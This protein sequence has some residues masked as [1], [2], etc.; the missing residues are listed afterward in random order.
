MS[1][2]PPLPTNTTCDIYRAGN[3]PPAPPD[4]AGVPCVLIPHSRNIKPPTTPPAPYTHVLRVA[5]NVDIRDAGPGGPDVIYVPNKSGVLYL[6][7][8]VTRQGRGTPLDHKEC[9][10]LRQNPTYP[11]DDG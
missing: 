4:V 8:W 6:V 2:S 9:L 11:T 1:A 7:Q 10:L 3:A 5:V